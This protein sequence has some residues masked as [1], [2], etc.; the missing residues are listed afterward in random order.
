MGQFKYVHR[1]QKTKNKLFDPKMLPRKL[2][3]PKLGIRDP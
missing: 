1:K 3:V 2:A